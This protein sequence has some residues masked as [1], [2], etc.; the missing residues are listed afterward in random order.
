MSNE[1]MTLKKPFYL[2][3]CCVILV[4]RLIK[5]NKPATECKFQKTEFPGTEVHAVIALIEN[6]FRI[7]FFFFI[8]LKKYF[9][10]GG[11]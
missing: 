10:R 6:R 4:V 2:V 11:F 3:L 9:K 1:T 5:S 8:S 7:E